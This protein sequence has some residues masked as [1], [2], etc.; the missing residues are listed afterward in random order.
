MYLTQVSECEAPVL[1]MFPRG[2]EAPDL[3]SSKKVSAP[4]LDCNMSRCG[5]QHLLGGPETQHSFNRSLYSTETRFHFHTL[6]AGR[7]GGGPQKV[8]SSMHFWKDLQSQ[9]FRKPDL[10]HSPQHR[11]PVP[12]GTPHPVPPSPRS[13]LPPKG[14]APRSAALPKEWLQNSRFEADPCSVSQKSY[15]PSR[16]QPRADPLTKKPRLEPI[17]SVESSPAHKSCSPNQPSPEPVNP[18]TFSTTPPGHG[19]SLGSTRRSPA[20]RGPAKGAAVR[21][22]VEEEVASAVGRR[23]EGSK[24]GSQ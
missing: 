4:Q 23:W 20:P 16:P 15:N 7:G 9:S 18:S 3:P 1:P 11:F 8:L 19:S 22:R 13:A 5:V 12:P 14:H 17:R 6:L 2:F 10:H 24:R 21:G